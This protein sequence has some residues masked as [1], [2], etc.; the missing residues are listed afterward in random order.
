MP[1]I[2]RFFGIVIRMFYADHQPAHFHAS[3]GKNHVK[4]R[5]DTMSVIDGELPSRALGLV[6]EWSAL[7]QKELLEC[8]N[9]AEESLPLDKIAPLE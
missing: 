8:W 1:E 2:S 4:I 7:H 5:I 6:I 3:Y 9:H